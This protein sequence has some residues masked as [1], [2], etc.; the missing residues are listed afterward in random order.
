MVHYE[1]FCSFSQRT[2]LVISRCWPFVS[3]RVV[4]GTRNGVGWRQHSWWVRGPAQIVGEEVVLD[5][6]RAETYYIHEPDDLLPDLAGL[7]GMMNDPRPKLDREILRFVARHG[8]LWHGPGQIGSGECRESL[9]D[10]FI[11]SGA[12]RDAALLYEALMEAIKEG[13]IEPIRVAKTTAFRLELLEEGLEEPLQSDWQ[14]LALTSMWI[15]DIVNQGLRGSQHL[16]TA[17]CGLA[18]PEIHRKPLGDPGVFLSD[19]RAETLE[20]AAYIHLSD[21]MTGNVKLAECPGCGRPFSP[22][23]GKQKYC[24]ES[25]AST[26]R[27]RR[28]KEKHAS[29][30]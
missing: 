26:T 29:P 25:C 16:M 27:W 28:Y 8:L 6:D 1:R 10:I 23:S 17:A 30:A 24:T 3:W 18:D 5:E 13:S 9:R 12:I 20:A 22:R 14:R 4:A 21:L 19:V 2:K 7:W 11:A 15:A